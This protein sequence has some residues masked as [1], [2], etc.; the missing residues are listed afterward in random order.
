MK[1]TIFIIVLLLSR[2]IVSSQPVNFAWV[3]SIGGTTSNH[4]G[5]SYDISTDANGNI[6][7][8]G[9]VYGVI[10]V[11]PG[12]A[13][14]N[15]TSTGQNY[16]DYYFSKCD[17]SGNLLWVKQF[18][19]SGS[20]Y[21]ADIAIDNQGNFYALGSYSGIVD[22]DPG[23]GTFT[24][25][26]GTNTYNSRTFL[27]KLDPAGNFIW[28]KTF[29]DYG[30]SGNI[31]FDGSGNI[32]LSGR[33]NGGDLDPGPGT[34]T[35]TTP[36]IYATKGFI[37]KL[38]N[39]A[40]LLWAKEVGGDGE[41]CSN[42]MVIDGAGNVYFATFFD[43]TGDFDPGPGTLTFSTQPN[44]QDYVL[45]KL[46]ASGNLVWANRYGSTGDDGCLVMM[47]DSNN[48]LITFNFFQAPLDFDPGPNTSTF[49]ATSDDLA[50]ARYDASGNLIWVKHIGGTY[51]D[52][53]WTGAID[54]NHNIYFAGNFV[55]TLDFDPGPGTAN[56]TYV[57]QTDGYV[58]KLDKN[59]NFIFVEQLAGTG[60]D[61]IWG[62]T[63]TSNEDILLTGSF[64]QV[65]DFDPG[66]GTH[67]LSSVGFSDA[68]TWKLTQNCNETVTLTTASA[69]LM[70]CAGESTTLTAS[71]TGN[72]VWY[73]AASGSSVIANGNQF[74]SP[75]LTAGS[76]TYYAA[77][78]GSVC[79][80]P[81]SAMVVTVGTCA[82]IGEQS[83]QK[84]MTIFPNPASS[85]IQIEV[86]DQTDDYKIEV[87]NSLGSQVLFPVIMKDKTRVDIS[88]LPPGVYF[89]KV[90]DG[91]W[92][93]TER[94][95]KK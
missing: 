44:N 61:L 26:Q 24:V 36:N 59:G 60:Q 57:A 66:I 45:S 56:L 83:V 52:V 86:V 91:S 39:S 35:V 67:T 62:M 13:V 23:A 85:E 33:F 17:P 87:F 31:R 63:L 47:I 65:S 70:M 81:R 40:N 42:T 11:D 29:A 94:L 48:D 78:Q 16:A 84:R 12:P 79:T 55:G 53:A 2:L 19:N 54:S 14:L 71:G 21:I 41:G 77:S 7:T 15:F 58:G 76:H 22:M 51:S 80:S 25:G 75:L 38:D 8:C 34:F 20:E 49:T 74:I 69:N 68:F 27:L 64:S 72:I 1:R 6:Y 5:D 9:H 92:S 10:D 28:V 32:Y 50:I 89:I 82:F 37:L 3:K 88:S 93:T 30:G 4:Q 18:G 73:N 95:L 90:S 46:D 43:G